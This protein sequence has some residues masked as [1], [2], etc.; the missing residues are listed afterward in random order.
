[1][2]VS[3]HQQKL[4]DELVKHAAEA[5]VRVEMPRTNNG[6]FK[7]H[8]KLL[9]NY[10]PF[11]KNKTAYVAGTTTGYPNVSPK[12]A[13]EMATTRPKPVSADE[14]DKRPS[15]PRKIR[16][17][18][19]KGKKCVK[20]HWCPTIIDLDTS[21]L[22]HIIPLDAGGLD[23]DNNRTLACEPCN[24]ARANKMPELDDHEHTES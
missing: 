13:V 19:L 11:S 6:H 18:L 4:I 21:T 2:S 14:K 16:K 1:M 17:R 9:V 5:D 3:V 23:N 22:D 7:L 10:Y 12:R 24:R 15:N 8:G 20:C